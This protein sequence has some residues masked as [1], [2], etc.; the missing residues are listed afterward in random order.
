[1]EVTGDMAFERLV[2]EMM[3]KHPNQAL[4][5]KQISAE[6]ARQGLRLVVSVNVRVETMQEHKASVGSNSS[7]FPT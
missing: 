5:L 7:H 1:M 2:D 6:A 4:T 3:D